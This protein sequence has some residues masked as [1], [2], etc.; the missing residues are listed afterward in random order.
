MSWRLIHLATG[1]VWAVPPLP[2][3]HLPHPCA[4]CGLSLPNCCASFTCACVGSLPGVSPSGCSSW[5]PLEDSAFAVGRGSDC[6]VRLVS[7]TCSRKHLFLRVLPP[8]LR[9]TLLPTEL[10][11]GKSSSEA[12]D[13]RSAGVPVASEKHI[14]LLRFPSRRAGRFFVRNA[15]PNGTLINGVLFGTVLKE[16]QQRQQQQQHKLLM[17]HQ[18][19]EIEQ[20]QQQQ[21][22]AWLLHT[23]YAEVF[24]GDLLELAGDPAL[25]LLVSFSPTSLCLDRNPDVTPKLRV[26]EESHV[27]HQEE[28]G[29]GKLLKCVRACHKAGLYLVAPRFHSSCC[30]LL[31]SSS[32]PAPSLPL[33][34]CVLCNKPLVQLSAVIDILLKGGDSEKSGSSRGVYL[35]ARISQAKAEHVCRLLKDSAAQRL[36]SDGGLLEGSTNDFLLIKDAETDWRFLVLHLAAA[37]ATGDSG[38]ECCVQG[39][40]YSHQPPHECLVA[41]L[42]RISPASSCVPASLCAYV[43]DPT[44]RIRGQLFAGCLVA[45]EAL[46]LASHSKTT[47][48]PVQSDV[49]TAATAVAAAL[50]PFLGGPPWGPPLC[51]ACCIFLGPGEDILDEPR[52]KALLLVLQIVAAALHQQQQNLPPQQKVQ[53]QQIQSEH[54]Q[55]DRQRALL[56]GGVRLLLARERQVAISVISGSVFTPDALFASKDIQ[57][58]NLQQE[59]VAHLSW[60]QLQYEQPLQVLR[61]EETQQPSG[62]FEAASCALSS[63]GGSRPSTLGA[64]P[65]GLPQPLAKGCAAD[66]CFYPDKSES[67]QTLSPLKASAEERGTHEA[68]GGA[69]G[70]VVSKVDLRGQETERPRGTQRQKA[71]AVARFAAIC[72]AIELASQPQPDQQDCPCLPAL[73]V[74]AVASAAVAQKASKAA[75]SGWLRKQQQQ[76][77]DLSTCGAESSTTKVLRCLRPVCVLQTNLKGDRKRF[78]KDTSQLPAWRM[79]NKAAPKAG[80]A[81]PFDSKGAAAG[82]FKSALRAA[83]SSRTLDRPPERAFTELHPDAIEVTAR[84][85]YSGDSFCSGNPG[86]STDTVCAETMSTVCQQ[87]LQQ[88][89]D[90]LFSRDG[91]D[92]ADCFQ[93]SEQAAAVAAGEASFP[94][95]RECLRGVDPQLP[96]GKAGRSAPPATLVSRAPGNRRSSYL[97]NFTPITAVVVSYSSTRSQKNSRAGCLPQ[98]VLELY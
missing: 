10:F 7:P 37:S 3:A 33:L 2:P 69:L 28:A 54:H 71:S 94:N 58:Q 81:L 29:R 91:G 45:E 22:A 70:C 98:T 62:D 42:R 31:L 36:P 17:H 63:A 61:E 20:R 93:Q 26:E 34:L 92:N 18:D 90:L 59:V 65:S 1:D 56:I 12:G 24:P 52:K 77:G 73:A 60:Q 30:C 82:S 68:S 84:E 85:N 35:A 79:A 23:G 16:Q 75:A 57:L 86:K 50:S 89:H 51:R 8:S 97:P 19:L 11:D 87:E 21:Q 64:E 5:G 40:E 55:K 95:S 47:Q 39:E 27:Q 66:P 74:P 78:R 43:K 48:L 38:S 25:S 67:F 41:A 15:S 6:A 88:Y 76:Q 13:S 80:A 46:S 9:D 14:E 72:E 96:Q 4:S 32:S 53:F 49:A 44:E 83:S